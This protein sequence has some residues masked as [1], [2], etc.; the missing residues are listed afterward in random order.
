VLISLHGRQR[1]TLVDYPRIKLIEEPNRTKLSPF[2]SAHHL[3]VS[4]LP[5]REQTSGPI[6][7]GSLGI[8]VPFRRRDVALK[9]LGFILMAA[10]PDTGRSRVVPRVGSHPIRRTWGEAHSGVS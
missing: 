9:R 4:W 8:V 3:S 7:N 10:F 1:V 6:Q 2:G 5:Q